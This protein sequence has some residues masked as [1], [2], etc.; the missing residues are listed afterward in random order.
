MCDKGFVQLRYL[1]IYYVGIRYLCPFPA[2]RF[3]AGAFG[4]LD[5][6]R[7]SVLVAVQ[8]SISV[9]VIF[10]ASVTVWPSRFWV[11]LGDVVFPL[12]RIARLH[13][14]AYSMTSQSGMEIG[15]AALYRL[16]SQQTLL[17]M[18]RSKLTTG[19]EIAW[20]LMA[21]CKEHPLSLDP[22][23]QVRH[24]LLLQIHYRMCS[25]GH[26][27]LWCEARRRLQKKPWVC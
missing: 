5:G 25:L 8:S 12:E 23:S 21:R 22:H 14:L 19:L 18:S 6:R 11:R 2:A 17:P 4:S 3:A 9:I 20:V 1:Y 27:M 16:S 26:S 24:L 10:S 13:R 7:F 15:I